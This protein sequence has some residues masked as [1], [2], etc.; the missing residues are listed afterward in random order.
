[1]KIEVHLLSQSQPMEYKD[2]QNAYT[3]DGMY[4]MLLEFGEVV[5]FPLVNI[6]RVKEF[7]NNVKDKSE[8]SSFSFE[9]LSTLDLNKIL[10]AKLE[11]LT[12][13]SLYKSEMYVLT[14]KDFNLILNKIFPNQVGYDNDTILIGNMIL[15]NIHI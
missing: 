6:F 1:M 3:K 14:D 4:C 15:K 8:L 7:E 13:S 12:P 9:N 5:K 2:V 11:D 10:N